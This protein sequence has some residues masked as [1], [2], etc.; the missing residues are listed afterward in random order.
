MTFRT[1]FVQPI[2]TGDRVQQN[3]IFD[4]MCKAISP[5]FL[6]VL[7]Y[8]VSQR[9]QTH[10][11]VFIVSCTLLS[12]SDLYFTLHRSSICYKTKTVRS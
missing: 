12:R 1:K 3:T 5:R 8:F 4:R 2:S 7:E 9:L 10:T 11:N 6:H